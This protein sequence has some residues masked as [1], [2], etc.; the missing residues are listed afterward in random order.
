MTDCKSAR[1]PFLSGNQ[2]DDGVDTP[3]V[4]STLHRKLVGNFLYITHTRPDLSYVV[5]VV[6]RFMQEPHELHWKAAKRILWY[7]K[8]T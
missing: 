5:G 3:L 8:G 1:S 4:A 6:S 7:V 2:M